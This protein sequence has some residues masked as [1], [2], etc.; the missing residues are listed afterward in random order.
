MT[1]E[2]DV[3]ALHYLE[4]YPLRGLDVNRA[5]LGF[6]YPTFRASLHLLEYTL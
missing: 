2:R 5:K 1:V 3:R 6:V 4:T